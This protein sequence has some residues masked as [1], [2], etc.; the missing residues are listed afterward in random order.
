MLVKVLGRRFESG[1][2]MKPQQMGDFLLRR[3]TGKHPGAPP[4]VGL[5]CTAEMD[6]ERVEG[7]C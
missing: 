5:L 7:G 2:S 3:S 4:L 1:C 6:L